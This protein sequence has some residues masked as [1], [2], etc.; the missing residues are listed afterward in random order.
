MALLAAAFLA[1]F[2]FVG[3]RPRPGSEPFKPQGLL[4]TW[5]MEDVTSVR[6]GKGTEQRSFARD[7]GGPWRSTEEDVRPELA[8]QIEAGLR[9]LRNSASE[10]DFSPEELGGRSLSE[11]G[12]EPPKLILT[13]R[14][15]GGT[16]ATIAFGDI[17]PLGLT[18]Y[19]RMD[20]RR[21]IAMLPSYVG[22]SWDEAL[23]SPR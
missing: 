9:L 7:P 13:A 14:T 3:E 19:V 21:D 18:Q 12:L 16:T 2:A 10:R 22:T 23:S 6:I 5:R 15:A 4:S 20:G 11:F 17:N 1:T 8:A